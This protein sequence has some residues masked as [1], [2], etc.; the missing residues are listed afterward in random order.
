MISKKGTPNMS[1]QG[2]FLWDKLTADGYVLRLR[3]EIK[4]QIKYPQRQKTDL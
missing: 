3:F 1:D 4:K 2:I